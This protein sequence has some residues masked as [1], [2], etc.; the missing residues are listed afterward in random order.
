M[1]CL[2][3]KVSL[4]I[5]NMSTDE[6]LF[7]YMSTQKSSDMTFVLFVRISILRTKRI[8]ILCIKLKLLQLKNLKHYI[9]YIYYTP[10]MNLFEKP[11]QKNSNQVNWLTNRLSARFPHSKTWTIFFYVLLT[12]F[13]LLLFEQIYIRCRPRLSFWDVS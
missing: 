4:N 9:F 12:K 6:K 2:D 3:R 5:F 10:D 7:P 13:C 11:G 1:F 8:H